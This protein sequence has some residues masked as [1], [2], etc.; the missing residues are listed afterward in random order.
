MPQS[1]RPARTA[2]A[3]SG[4]VGQ[5]GLTVAERVE[6]KP[7]AR[8]EREQQQL[9]AG[10]RRAAAPAAR[11]LAADARDVG[12]AQ[13]DCPAPPR[14]PCSRARKRDHAPRRAARTRSPPPRRWRAR[15]RRRAGAD[16]SPPPSPRRAR[17]AASPASLPSG[18]L[19]SPSRSRAAPI[20]AADR[21]CRRRSAAPA[22]ARALP[23][24]MS[25]AASQ[26]SSAAFGNSH[27]PVTLVQGTAPFATSS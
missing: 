1:A 14:R 12:R 10:A 24:L 23:A 26:R 5:A 21:G 20:P 16:G 27:L 3:I 18:R 17:A 22:R 2:C 15:R 7:G 6:R 8:D 4:P 11:A 9:R 19:A 25:P 13:A